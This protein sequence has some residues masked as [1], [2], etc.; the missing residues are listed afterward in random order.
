MCLRL[1]YQI[2]QGTKKSFFLHAHSVFLWPELSSFEHSLACTLKGK[3]KKK[4]KPN[5]K[6]SPA[7]VVFP[8]RADERNSKP[9]VTGISHI[10]EYTAGRSHG[11]KAVGE[12]LQY[13]CLNSFR[14]QAKTPFHTLG[15]YT[16][17]NCFYFCCKCQG[18][19]ILQIIKILF[20]CR[21]PIS[22]QQL[23]ILLSNL[24]PFIF[25]LFMLCAI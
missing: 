18:K 20:I 11:E 19:L 16:T 5:A 13:C 12:P 22:K 17:S 4:A 6:Y 23:V 1:Q 3:K 7:H 8:P 24:W 21:K 9:H 14:F 2:P 15:I 25:W 10:A